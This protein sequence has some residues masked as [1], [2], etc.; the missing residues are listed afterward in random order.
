[1][2]KLHCISACKTFLTNCNSKMNVDPV[3]KYI[4][5]VH[6]Q[7]WYNWNI[8]ERG[9]KHHKPPPCISLVANSNGIVNKWWYGPVLKYMYNYMYFLCSK[10][11]NVMLKE[12]CSCTQNACTLYIYPC[13]ILE[14]NVR[15]NF[16]RVFKMHVHC[17]CIAYNLKQTN[18][19]KNFPP[20]L[21]YMYITCYICTIFPQE[22]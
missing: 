1:M 6:P 3:L 12:F 18:T 17:T 2:N 7:P 8:V 11:L 5:I 15:M 13:S 16:A 21:K 20:I 19:K 22:F 9:T 10:Q 14:C 4:Y